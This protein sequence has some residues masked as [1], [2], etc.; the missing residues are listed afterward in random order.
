MKNTKFYYQ[1]V[2]AL[3]G[4][5]LLYES[6]WGL[7]AFLLALLI[8]GLVLWSKRLAPLPA[9]LFVFAGLLV[10]ISAS[11]LSLV[12]FWLL[13]FILIGSS[14]HHYSW[15]VAIPEGISRL[16]KGGWLFMRG[17]NKVLFPGFSM[18]KSL[19]L[20]LPPLGITLIFYALYANASPVFAS[21]ASLAQLHLPDFSWFLLFFC[22]LWGSYALAYAHPQSRLEAWDARQPDVLLRR[23]RKTILN[24]FWLRYEYK[25]ALL[26]LG[27]LNALLLLFHSI[28][29]TTLLEGKPGA[30]ITYA[31]WVH[32]GV[33][34]LI[35][36]IVMAAALLVYV[37]RGNLNFFQ[38]NQP[39]LLLAKAWIIQNLLLALTTA[40]KNSWYIGSYG[41]TYKR[42]GVWVYL[43]LVLIGLIS[44]W[45]KISEKQTLWWMVKGN[46]RASII[47]LLLVTAFPWV[48]II[49]WYNLEKAQI[50]DNSYLLGLSLHNTDQLLQHKTIFSYQQQLNLHSRRIRL[51]ESIKT[52]NWKSWTLLNY[53]AKQNLETTK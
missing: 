9:L 27:L 33:G 36:S 2:A 26:V 25:T 17:R 16:L 14:Q 38:Q 12:L 50:T 37:F 45:I 41:L 4:T 52:D 20:S 51:E 40:L 24:P 30:G 21:K 8:L 42:I 11:A 6:F 43:I 46:F 31:E 13:L 28:D 53:Y 29:I 23:R 1:A 49:T 18:S 15:L 5:W 47:V 32:Q 22:L 48:R 10:A 7:N 44:T 39:L 3:A 34:T 19:L 35:V